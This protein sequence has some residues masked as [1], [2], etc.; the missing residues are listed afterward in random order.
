MR[1]LV[2]VLVY[3]TIAVVASWGGF[4]LVH[5]FDADFTPFAVPAIAGGIMAVLL[6]LDPFR[7]RKKHDAT[8]HRSR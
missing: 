4:A 6:Y 2:A 7:L 8:N 3:I 5:L 1:F